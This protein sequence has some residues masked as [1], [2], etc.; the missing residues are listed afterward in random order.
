MR[1][2]RYHTHRRA[3][4]S[5]YCLQHL[6]SPQLPKPCKH[7]AERAVMTNADALV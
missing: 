2:G 7:K 3:P 6:D 1:V 5:A 4:S